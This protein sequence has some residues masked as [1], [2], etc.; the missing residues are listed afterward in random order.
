MAL[1]QA[2]WA[3]RGAVVAVIF[4]RIGAFAGLRSAVAF[5][6]M[7]FRFVLSVGFWARPLINN[8]TVNLKKASAEAA[9]RT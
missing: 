6:Y 1:S 5:L 9:L 8:A 7:T 3:Q 2:F 4:G